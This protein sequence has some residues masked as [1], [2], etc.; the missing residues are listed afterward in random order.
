MSEILFWGL[1]QI[2]L[3]MADGIAAADPESK[4]A[5]FDDSRNRRKRADQS[6]LFQR[7]VPNPE[8]SL[9]SANLILLHDTLGP[10]EEVFPI[11]SGQ[12]QPGSLVIDFAFLKSEGMPLATAHFPEE[13]YYLAASIVHGHLEGPPSKL[14]FD[15]G[16]LAIVNPEGTP[17]QAIQVAEVIAQNLGLRPYFLEASESD[18]ANLVSE[19]LPVL[20]EAALMNSLADSSGWREM[21]RLLN[22]DVAAGLMKDDLDAA[23]L[24]HTLSIAPE[25]IQHRLESVIQGLQELRLFIQ[26]GDANQLE[27]RLESAIQTFQEWEA[28]RSLGAATGQDVGS[29]DIPKVGLLR[30]LLGMPGRRKDK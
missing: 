3:A 16:L 7:V 14:W 24:A 23:R 17:Q 20:L 21:Q 28:D 2:A 6:K 25:L 27:A 11:L 9:G 10:A 13:C 1:T 26:A 30:S 5:G 12:L 8:K 4:L 29:T 15:G 19:A 22:L 18:S